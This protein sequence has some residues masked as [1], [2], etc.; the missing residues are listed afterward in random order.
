[1]RRWAGQAAR[2][3]ATNGARAAILLARLAMA[4]T[5]LAAFA[6]TAAAWRLST[7][8]VALP[9]LVDAASR[10]ASGP[11]HMVTFDR[12]VVSWTGFAR[13]DAQPLRL[14]AGGVRATGGFGEAR[15]A[16]AV[17]ALPVLPLLSGQIEPETAELD[18]LRL[19]LAAG[20]GTAAGGGGGS[21]RNPAALLR[22]VLKQ[23]DDQPWSR[24]RHLRIHDVSAEMAGAPGRLDRMDIDLDRPEAGGLTGKATM[25]VSAA[26][27]NATVTLAAQMAADGRGTEIQADL[28]P[29]SPARLA[30]A[31]ADLAPLATLDAPVT[32][33]GR[34]S[35][36]A[37]LELVAAEAAIA[38]GPGTVH[39]GTGTAPVL[40]AD[41]R[42][43]VTPGKAELQVVR[44][45]TAPMPDG[46]RTRFVGQAIGT[47]SASGGYAITASLDVDRIDFADLP[48]LW[49][50]GTG[51]PGT[52]PWMTENITEGLLAN[53]HVEMDLTLPADLSDV[54]L[55]R[56]A[57]GIDGHDLTV[58]WL[59]PVPPIVHGEARLT[60]GDPDIIDIAV[61]TA[62]QAGGRHGGM[63]YRD[64]TIHLTGIA[65]R[66]QF[67]DIRTGL[68]GPLA[69]LLI[70]LGHPRIAL[71]SKRPLPMRDPSGEIA[72]M[73]SVGRLPLRNDVLMDDLVIETTAR[74][75]RVH[76]GGIAAGYDLDE[77]TIDLK[78]SNNGLSVDG[79]ARLAGFMSHLN[80]GMDF[81]AGPPG[82]VQQ[83]VSARSTIEMAKLGRFGIDTGSLLGGSAELGTTL[84]S[85]RGGA[86]E[87]ALAADLTRLTIDVPRMGLRKAV[88]EAGNAAVRVALDGAR[89]ASI[90]RL[91][92]RTSGIEVLGEA[93]IESG[94]PR[95]LLLERLILG[96]GT[97]LHGELR[98]A[99]DADKVTVRL[100]G[101]SFDLSP[102]LGGS[103]RSAF[104]TGRGGDGG[105]KGSK[106]GGRPWSADIAVDRVILGPGRALLGVRATADSDGALLRSAA[107]T[108]RVEGPGGPPIAASITPDS[109][110]R[111]LSVD[112]PDAGALMH[113]ADITNALIGGRLRLTARWA[114]RA[115]DSPLAGVMEMTDFRVRDAPSI[116]RV[117]QGLTIYGLVELARGPGLGFRRMVAPFALE[118]GVLSLR[119]VIAF[120]ASLGFTA[121]GR[122]DLRRRVA[123]VAG[124]VV[125]AYFF[126]SLLGR[127]PLIG[128]I[129]TAE[130]GGGLFAA[131]VT[132]AGPLDDLSVRVNP[133]SLL[134]PGA[135]RG[136]FG[137]ATP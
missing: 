131:A 73:V 36:N 15:L 31:A 74:A 70:T 83:T 51:G 85:R 119:N 125:P 136:L 63:R 69:D 42:L 13:L 71:L 55:T 68:V 53:G 10:A 5:L 127:V 32:L 77:G 103:D 101:P 86:T 128:R 52:R 88:G 58:H 133:L 80:I 46:A 2:L 45:D 137:S 8:P 14:E 79:T 97:N 22:R 134:T 87:I 115:P 34:A 20:A 64:A 23:D 26:G 118:D 3:G 25:G 49:P 107:V 12:L 38:I 56:I 21:P 59:R 117:L 124:T 27:Q 44:L 78:A 62:M 123:D 16:R 96:K 60:V 90:D 4:A 93:I 112:L 6:V 82:Q 105:G 43:A 102:A 81:R 111:R 50:E 106:L 72:A 48:A 11:D 129:F 104:G 120:S 30:G 57:G 66:R 40:G 65:G 98:M 89:I 100:A 91:S 9:W 121:R 135:L 17:I 109:G 29:I 37:T 19:R 116:G 76:L 47:S 92:I 54:A 39:A 7:G 24:L 126:N 1:M 99:G 95:G 113:A 110:G 67:A 35:L 41:L 18:G 108:G 114:D 130:K 84:T 132:I 94:A 28:T 75:T 122:I 33:S 61:P